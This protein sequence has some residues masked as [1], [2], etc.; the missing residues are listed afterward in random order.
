MTLAPAF[1][2]A[3]MRVTVIPIIMK[4]VATRAPMK[5]A[6]TAQYKDKPA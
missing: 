6:G 1:R 4:L 2:I 5:Q 3:I